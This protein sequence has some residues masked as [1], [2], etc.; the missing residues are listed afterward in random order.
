MHGQ[1]KE[2]HV[3]SAV[4][5]GAC[6]LIC[7]EADDYTSSLHIFYLYPSEFYF[8]ICRVGRSHT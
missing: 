1:G 7:S 2:G 3:P 6:M 8:F 5:L 4:S